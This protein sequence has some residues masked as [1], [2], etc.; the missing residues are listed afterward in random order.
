MRMLVLSAWRSLVHVAGWEM[1]FLGSMPRTEWILKTQQFDQTL[2]CVSLILET[3]VKICP[4]KK[5]AEEKINI[6]LFT[7]LG[8]GRET[9]EETGSSLPPWNFQALL[10]TKQCALGYL[11]IT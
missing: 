10:S 5:S 4:T 3:L 1:N 11:N 2:H 6:F 8:K 9:G 7:R